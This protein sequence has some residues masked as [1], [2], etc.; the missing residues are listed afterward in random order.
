MKLL[1]VWQSSLL[2][3]Y[4]APVHK[5]DSGFSHAQVLETGISLCETL[6]RRCRLLQIHTYIYRSVGGWASRFW[7]VSTGRTDPQL[8]KIY[9]SSTSVVVESPGSGVYPLGGLTPSCYN[10]ECLHQGHLN[11]LERMKNHTP[12]FHQYLDENDE[13]MIDWGLENIHEIGN[14]MYRRYPKVTDRAGKK[15]EDR[16]RKPT[17][18]NLPKTVTWD[19]IKT[20]HVTYGVPLVRELQ[21]NEGVHSKLALDYHRVFLQRMPEFTVE[22]KNLVPAPKMTN[23]YW[24][25]VRMTGTRAA[26]PAVGTTVTIDI[27]DSRPAKKGREMF[28]EHRCY[29]KV[30]SRMFTGGKV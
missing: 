11:L 17:Y 20:F 7:C 1:H 8:V 19:S 26:V 5:I 24:V 30:D 12:P 4:F 10:L 2:G 6:S 15:V 27:E 9:K 23:T 29:G 21:Y 3:L 18:Y 28:G 25:G 22:G 13:P 16:S 14:G